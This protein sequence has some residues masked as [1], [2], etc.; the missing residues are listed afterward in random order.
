MSTLASIRNV[1]FIGIGGI[2]MS[3]IA[4]YFLANG[5]NVFGYD[6]TR[7]VLTE[8]LEL[9]GM[10]IHYTDDVS[11]IPE[12]I[13][14]VIYTPAVPQDHKELNY[15][16]DNGFEVIKRSEALGWISRDKKSIAIAGTHGKTTTSTLTAHV[17]KQGGID[18]SAFLGGIAVDYDS[19]FLIGKS[20]WVVLEADE[21]DRSFLRLTPYFAAILSMDPDHLDI[22]GDSDTMKEGYLEFAG[23]V[24]EG[25]V[26]LIREDLK[27]YFKEAQLKQFEKN[28]VTFLTFG[29]ENADIKL[30]GIRVNDGKFVFDYTFRDHDWKGI[31]INLPGRHNAEN[32]LVAI[33]FGILCG[34]TESKIRQALSGFKGIQRRFERVFESEDVVYI[35]DYAHHPTELKA[36]IEA[37]GALYPDRKLTGIFQPHLYSR[38]RDFADGFAEEL[39]KLDEIILMD[40]YPARELPIVGVDSNLI[41]DKLKNINKILVTK[42]TLM[43]ALESRR[44]EVLLTLGAGDID[45]F[46]PLIKE[47]LANGH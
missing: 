32:A 42:D 6:R 23:K 19:N 47:K 27:K 7:T 35:D 9:E 3:A 28:G 45:T 38:T 37:A 22:Y 11:Q 41:F 17:L 25:G 24:A 43:K 15:F 13:E 29:Y 36:A 20:E 10:M 21:Y 2:G 4:R 5:R 40:I 33:T 46:V 26:M 8:K 44:P 1:Y 34:L 30:S 16:L 12:E 14:L 31:H 39:D 18:V